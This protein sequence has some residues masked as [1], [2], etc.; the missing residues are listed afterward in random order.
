MPCPDVFVQ[1]VPEALLRKGLVFSC[2]LDPSRQAVIDDAHAVRINYET[3]L[4]AD[5]LARDVFLGD[6]IAY[7]GLVTDPVTKHRFRPTVDS[8]TLTDVQTGVL[9]VFEDADSLRMFEMDPDG[10]RL[11]GYTM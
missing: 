2:Y 6:V 8:P 3:Y 7:C 10:F 9:Y 4:F 5:T 11:P 1:D